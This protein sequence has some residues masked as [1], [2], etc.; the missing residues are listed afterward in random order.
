MPITSKSFLIW[1][2]EL[3]TCSNLSETDH[4]N[5]VSRSYYSAYHETL[6]L[7]DQNLSLGV[8]NMK[9]GSHIKLSDTL[10]NFICQNKERQA[11]IR[12]LG[13]R[14][15]AMHALRVR[16]DY[17]LDEHITNTEAMSQVKNVTSIFSIIENETN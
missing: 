9:G 2:Q 10:C 13:T 8:S 15:H 1:S 16:A 6:H 4:R 5:I 7:A 12:R 14:I 17:F 11:T 3:L